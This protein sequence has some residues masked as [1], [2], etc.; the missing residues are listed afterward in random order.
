MDTSYT[1]QVPD[2]ESA[3][4]KVLPPLNL[5]YVGWTE[6]GE[7]FNL[8]VQAAEAGPYTADILYTAH[9]DAGISFS[10]ND[11]P[12]AMACTLTS[13]FDATDPIPWRQWHHWN[14]ARDAVIL[15]LPK[16]ISVIKV[17]IVSGGNINLATLAFR[18]AGT[19]RKGPPITELKT[20]LPPVTKP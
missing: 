8:T 5:L 2:R 4:N 19:A 17:K 11:D 10:I 13:T 15:T 1:K 14:T 20:A 12:V 3:S 16:G 9:N 6:A 18:P 7:W